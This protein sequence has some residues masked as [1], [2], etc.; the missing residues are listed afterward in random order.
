M[1][2]E[3]LKLR[4]RFFRLGIV[5]ALFSGCSFETTYQDLSEGRRFKGLI[6]AE[7]EIVR[8]VY[9]YGIRRSSGDRVEYVLLQ[10]PPGFSGPEVGFR[11]LVPN[12]TRFKILKVLKT[13]RVFDPPYS[14]EIEFQ[15]FGQSWGLPVRID[16]M[17]G[18]EINGAV[19]LNP[20]IYRELQ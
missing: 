4:R 5:A 1:K 14:L 9:A 13:N 11:T 10:P 20:Q 12:G 16:L 2:T 6:G 15:N 17:Q 19:Q 7:Y 3:N 18:N 8:T